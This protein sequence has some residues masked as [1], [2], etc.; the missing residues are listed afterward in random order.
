VH[1]AKNTLGKRCLSIQKRGGGERPKPMK[2]AGAVM[3]RMQVQKKNSVW[4]FCSSMSHK[5]SEKSQTSAAELK[6][7]KHKRIKVR[8]KRNRDLGR[9]VP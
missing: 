4:K 7:K 9:I 6:R 5:K 1:K 2:R 8:K 3:K